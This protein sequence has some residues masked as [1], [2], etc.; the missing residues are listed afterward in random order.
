MNKQDK[1]YQVF[2]SSTY[3]DLIE[4]RQ[5]VIH[6]LLELDCIPAGMELFPA[7]DEDQWTLIKQVIDDCDYYIVIIA[8]RYG[9]EDNEGMSYTE[10]EYRYAL[11]TN[12]PIIAFLHEN[13]DNLPG[14]K[15]EKND[16]KREKLDEFRKFVSKKMI[17]SWTNAKDLGSVVSRSLIKLIKQRPAIGWMRADQIPSEDITNELLKLRR[18]IEELETELETERKRPPK[19]SEKYAQGDQFFQIKYIFS[20]RGEKEIFSERYEDKTFLTWNNVFSYISPSM[21]DENA[22]YGLKKRI[23][24]FITEKEY[25]YK[26]QKFENVKK[27]Q[28]SEESFDLIIVQ[29][30]ALGLI[31]QSKKKHTASDTNKYWSL[32]EYGERTMMRLRALKNVE[33]FEGEL[34]VIE[35]KVIIQFQR[36]IKDS[37]IELPELTYS[38]NGYIGK[39]HVI[40]LSINGKEMNSI[41]ESIKDLKF[42]EVLQ[43]T[44]SELEYL[45]K[46]IGELINLIKLDLNGNNLKYIPNEL[47]KLKKLIELDLSENEINKIPDS[48]GKLINLEY[49]DLFEN[50]IDYFPKALEKLKN[51]KILNIKF[52]EIDNFPNCITALENL[53]ELLMTGGKFTSIP[54]SL[55]ELKNLEILWIECDEISSIPKSIKNLINL[56]ELT[57]FSEKLSKLPIEISELINLKELD[58]SYCSFSVLPESILNLKNL[59]LLKIDYNLIKPLSDQIE[60]VLT[61]LEQQGCIISKKIS[62]DQY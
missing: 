45:T 23:N 33:Y 57:L 38:D 35:R 48:I 11:E 50:Q 40:Q 24:S 55:F 22:E 15:L 20:T 3:E 19:D 13:P 32:T 25:K 14:I 5:E 43:I 58:I 56:T 16:E 21:L 46:S 47:G 17:K 12:K 39:E 34:S 53:R 51:L 2:V 30:F 18:R 54:E 9:S 37:V 26:S 42:L 59:E 7:A 4:E 8:G 44:N 41:P 60:S 6:A 28:I 10:K 29:F 36:L 1:R 49:L 27:F 31:E 52:G 61:K 62:E